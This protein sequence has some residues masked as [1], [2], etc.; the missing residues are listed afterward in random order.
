VATRRKNP[1]LAKIGL[2]LTLDS[3]LTGPPADG[4]THSKIAN[5]WGTLLETPDLP[6]EGKSGPPTKNRF[7][8]DMVWAL[9]S[10][11]IDCTRILDG[12]IQNLWPMVGAAA[13]IALMSTDR[14]SSDWRI[15]DE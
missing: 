3:P 6:Q 15:R 7:S 11:K 1:A 12:T 14:N 10:M 2:E 5:V 9:A 8:L 4:P 13:L